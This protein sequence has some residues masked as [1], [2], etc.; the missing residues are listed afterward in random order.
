MDSPGQPPQAPNPTQ[1]RIDGDG[2]API[3]RI[4]V[5][6]RTTKAINYRHRSGSD[7]TQGPPC[8]VYTGKPVSRKTPT[9]K[10][11]PRLHPSRLDL[12]IY[13]GL[14]IATLAV[15]SQVGSHDFVDYD[16]PIYVV[17]NPHVRDGFTWDGVRWAFTSIDDANWFPLTRLSHI[18]DCQI[19]G[20]DAGMQHWTNLVLHA[21]STLLLFA[22]LK[23]MTAARWP[24]AFVA[25]AFRVASLASRIGGV[26]FGAQGRSQRGLLVCNRLGLPAIRRTAFAGAVP[27]RHGGV[28]VRTNVQTDD[29]HA[30]LR[31]SAD[32]LLA[33]AAAG[34]VSRVSGKTAVDRALHRRI[35]DHADCAEP[36]PER[37]RSPACS[38]GATRGKRGYLL[39]RLHRT[40]SLAGEPCGLLSLSRRVSGVAMDS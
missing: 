33:V 3:Y 26:D 22:L 1:Q 6:A 11:E 35:S 5:V 40:I 9:R 27:R 10:S 18:L 8:W 12:C 37:R 13:A 14:L 2:S 32:R 38:A 23:R 28:R 34:D 20:L 17:N 4:T 31:A 30:A 36:G 19:F 7:E 16:D 39:R 24:G 21:M 29:R 25:L 15:Y